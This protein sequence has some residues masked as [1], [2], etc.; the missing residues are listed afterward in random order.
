MSFLP[1]TEVFSNPPADVVA[2]SQHLACYAK[3]SADS[4]S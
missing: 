2:A 1:L 3:K 4:W